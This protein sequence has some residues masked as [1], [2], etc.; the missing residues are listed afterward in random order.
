MGVLF[1]S[2][3]R[4]VSLSRGVMDFIGAGRCAP[5]NLVSGGDIRKICFTLSNGK[6][7]RVGVG[8][9]GSTAIGL[10]F[11]A[12][13]CSGNRCGAIVLA[14]RLCGARKVYFRVLSGSTFSVNNVRVFC[15]GAN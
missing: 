4:M 12:S 10:H 1:G 3:S 13:S 8:S 15:E 6:G 7:I 2:G 14:P 11:S 5:S 9:G